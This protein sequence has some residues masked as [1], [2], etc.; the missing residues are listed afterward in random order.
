MYVMTL[1]VSPVADQVSL[2]RMGIDGDARVN[3]GLDAITST[4]R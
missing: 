4:R 2:K 3:V 1:I